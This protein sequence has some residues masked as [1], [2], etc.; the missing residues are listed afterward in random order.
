MFAIVSADGWRLKASPAVVP[1]RG[2]SSRAREVPPV[3][4]EPQRRG[5]GEA[6][7][8]LRGA[9]V[10]LGLLAAASAAVSWQAQY[11]MVLGVKHA[12]MVAA[13][14]AGIPDA[15]ALIFA[16]LGVAVAL[17]GRRAVRPRVLNAAC[18]AVSLAMNALAAR[19]GWRDLAIWVM[20]AAVYALAS[21]TL[22]GVVRAQAVA[23]LRAEGPGLGD[24]GP[25]LLGTLGG[26]ALWVLRLVLAGPSTLRGFRAWVVEECPVAPGRK[27]GL[28]DQ[29]RM[30]V[31]VTPRPARELE[32]A[33]RQQRRRRD[34]VPSKRDR[35]VRLAGERRDLARVP[36]GEVS[37]LATALAGEIGY[38][39][40]TAR[41]ELLR[42]VRELQ[43]GSA[44]KRSAGREAVRGE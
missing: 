30:T 7:W 40:G 34:G 24:D 12:Q 35:L 44:A 26:V 37:G 18:I 23:R 6:G 8:W 14:E 9:A 17:H 22:I 21:D 4:V 16:A 27:A 2:V 36:L 31:S 5:P 13:V 19:H 11:V 32:P 41:R 3:E 10:V 39:A 43:S 25:D 42:H 20:P 28:A 29:P 1:D 33:Q 38:S 15:G